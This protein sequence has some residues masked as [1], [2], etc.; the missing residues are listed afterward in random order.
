M[1]DYEKKIIPEISCNVD[2]MTGEEISFAV[3][4]LYEAGAMDVI[5][6]PINMKKNRPGIMIRIACG[7]EAKPAIIEA[8]FRYTTTIGVRETE[9]VR[10]TLDRRMES[11]ETSLGTMRKKISEGYGVTR[12][13]WEFEDLAR[14]ARD[15]D[16]TLRDVKE[17]LDQEEAT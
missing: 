9:T 15:N 13:K 11:R 10:Y 6:L 5:T 4:K 3:D 12:E 17:I 2:D 16:M 14:A 8:V 1:M 7:E